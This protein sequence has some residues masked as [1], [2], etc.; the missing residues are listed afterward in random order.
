MSLKHKLI[1]FSVTWLVLILILFN[2]FV[3]M[4][5]IKITSESEVQLLISRANEMLDD[6]RLLYVELWQTRPDLLNQYLQGNELI[7]IVSPSGKVV[8]EAYNDDIVGRKAV[9]YYNR[10]HSDLISSGTEWLVYVQ[11]PIMKNSKQI[12]M[13]EIGHRLS[14]LQ[15]YLKILIFA[16]TITSVGGLILSVIGGYMYTSYLVRPIHRIIITMKEIQKSGDFRKIEFESKSKRDELVVLV[17]AF[18][19]MIERLE[20]N[21]YQQKH[22]VA[23]ASHELKTPLTIIESYASILKRWGGKDAKIREEAVEAIY[24]EAMRLKQLTQ[25][26]LLLAS[27]E[28]EQWIKPERFELVSAV[29]ET[30]VLLEQTFQR[31]IDVLADPETIEMT[32][33]REKI[34][35]VII[36]LLDN[37]IKYSK[38]E[39]TVRVK[40]TR[41]NVKIEVIDR[42]IG[43]PPE[44][45]P[46]LFERFHRVDKARNRSTGGAGLGLSIAQ[47]IVRHLN[48]DIAVFSELHKGSTMTV[49]LQKHM[50]SI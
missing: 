47:S 28:Q 5:F 7:R 8:H 43:I 46:L 32:S 9:M 1:L 42:G 21:F 20:H 23:D 31:R 18:N 17:T 39:I 13:L 6:E 27:A 26:L 38:I 50:D 19:Q 37:A 40:E 11:M 49:H 10:F 24:S 4:I 36:I 34:K 22:F 2:I 41:N 16:L 45:I 35:Q 48:G 14:L 3:Y 29:R 25:S 30:A 12:G 33:D 44:H 15:N